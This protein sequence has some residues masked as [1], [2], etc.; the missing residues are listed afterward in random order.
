MQN[1]FMQQRLPDLLRLFQQ[2]K[3]GTALGPQPMIP[4]PVQG[5]QPEDPMQVQ[6]PPQTQPQ[7]Q[8]SG[9]PDIQ[10]LI[11]ALSNQQSSPR[12]TREDHPPSEQDRLY[13]I[14]GAV[15]SGKHDTQDMLDRP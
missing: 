11:A 2:Q 1:P 10:S 7:A 13:A 9:M 3:L 15:M 6:L 5:P 14:L 4:Q 8:P 12:P